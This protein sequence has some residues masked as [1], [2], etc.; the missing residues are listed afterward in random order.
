MIAKLAQQ[1]PNLLGAIQKRVVFSPADLEAANPNLVGGDPHA[2]AP[3]PNQ[4]F[5]FRPMPGVPSHHT[6]I[7]GLYHIGASTH[8]GAG[9]HGASGVL[10]AQALGAG[11]VKRACASPSAQGRE[12]GSFRV[13][14]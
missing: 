13:E 9:L 12:I 3:T 5:I 6:P 4:F 8:P 14:P 2:G 11:K 1:I 10:V 7:P